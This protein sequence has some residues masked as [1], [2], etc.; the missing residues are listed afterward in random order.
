MN[1]YQTE[2]ERAERREKRER[3]SGGEVVCERERARW[4]ER[5]RNT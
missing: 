3:E 1:K 4:G 2:S 5:E